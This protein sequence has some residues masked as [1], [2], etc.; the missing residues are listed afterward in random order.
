METELLNDVYDRI[1]TNGIT[2]AMTDLF[3]GLRDIR[4]SLS[5]QEWDTTVRSTLL[6]HPLRTLV[7]SDPFTRRSFLKPRGYAG[8][9]SFA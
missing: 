4:L 7:H 6:T 3:H 8:R 1:R 2:E 5:R 9:R